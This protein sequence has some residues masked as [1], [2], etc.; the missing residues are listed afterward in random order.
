MEEREELYRCRVV[1]SENGPAFED[2]LLELLRAG[3]GE[4]VEAW[5]LPR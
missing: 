5:A 3:E 2:V 1:F 4:G